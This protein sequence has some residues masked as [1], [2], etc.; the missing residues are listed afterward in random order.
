MNKLL[1]ALTNEFNY[2]TT[3]NGAIALKSTKSKVYDMFAFGGAYRTRS[4]ADCI[5][6]FKNAIEENPLLGLKC[7]FYLRDARGGKLVA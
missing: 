3:E 7:L 5:L 4:E 6:L 1:N 2:K